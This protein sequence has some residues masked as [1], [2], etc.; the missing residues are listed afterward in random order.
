MVLSRGRPPISFDYAACRQAGHP[1]YYLPK[2]TRLNLLVPLPASRGHRHEPQQLKHPAKI[3]IR[4][5]K[6][7]WHTWPTFSWTKR[8]SPTPPCPA[9]PTDIAYRLISLT[10][11]SPIEITTPP[12]LSARVALSIWVVNSCVCFFQVLFLEMTIRRW[13]KSLDN[14]L[15]NFFTY[16]YSM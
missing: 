10:S 9:R 6:S 11:N 8:H 14:Y 15:S 7:T 16:V 3:N 4:N 1:R 2:T 5:Q 13:F 12:L